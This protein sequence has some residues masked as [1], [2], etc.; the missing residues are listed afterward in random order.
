MNQ[1]IRN[2]SLKNEETLEEQDY[3]I[4][5]KEINTLVE[6]LKR[7]FLFDC[8]KQAFIMHKM[9]W[10]S[11]PINTIFKKAYIEKYLK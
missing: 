1:I 3:S 8:F 11:V 7:K 6:C 5:F 2:D 9:N 4:V 10:A